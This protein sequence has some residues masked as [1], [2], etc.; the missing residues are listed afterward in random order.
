MLM[1]MCVCMRECLQWRE[2]CVQSGT[3]C[4]GCSWV[5]LMRTGMEVVVLDGVF[6]GFARFN[7]FMALT[8]AFESLQ[9]TVTS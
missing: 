5:V 2:D 7:G 6:V 3:D 4:R 1:C 8:S 9:R